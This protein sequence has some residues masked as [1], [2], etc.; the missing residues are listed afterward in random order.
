M[1]ICNLSSHQWK[2][3]TNGF[4][5][6]DYITTLKLFTVRRLLLRMARMEM[7]ETSKN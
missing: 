6:K 4:V 1:L 7:D 5:S 2:P 3:K